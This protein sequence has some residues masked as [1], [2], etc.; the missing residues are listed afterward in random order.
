MLLGNYPEDVA[1]MYVD[2]PRSLEQVNEASIRLSG[3]GMFGQY[4]E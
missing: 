1:V 3:A 2:E 4:V